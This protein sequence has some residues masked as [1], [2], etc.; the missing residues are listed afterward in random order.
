[1][2]SVSKGDHVHGLEKRYRYGVVAGIGE[3]KPF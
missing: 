2:D 1:M 3:P